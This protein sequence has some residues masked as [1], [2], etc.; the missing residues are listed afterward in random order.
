MPITIDEYLALDIEEPTELVRGTVVRKQFPYPSHGIIC[1]NIC[2][3][4][5]KCVK[6]EKCGTGIALHGVITRRN[7]DSLRTIDVGYYSK[8]RLPRNLI[9]NKHLPIAP[10]VLFEVVSHD[11]TWSYIVE[12]MNEFIEAGTLVASVINP[13]FQTVQVFQ[14]H[15]PFQTLRNT[16]VLSVPLIPGFQIP[17]CELFA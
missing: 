13:V 3:E 17:V 14:Q 5:G 9:S 4:V 7:P 12:K 1:A 6:A 11:E 16:D 2:Y 15:R 10:E 8:M